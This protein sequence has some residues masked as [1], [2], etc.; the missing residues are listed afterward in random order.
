MKNITHCAMS[1]TLLNELPLGDYRIMQDGYISHTIKIYESP[2]RIIFYKEN[3]YTPDAYVD[4]Y[5]SHFKECRV[6][7]LKND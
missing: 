7:K 4:M 6:V 1:A 3:V 5:A 2:R